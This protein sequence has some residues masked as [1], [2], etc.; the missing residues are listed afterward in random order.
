TKLRDV[1][2]MLQRLADDATKCRQY[3][4]RYF[5][6]EFGPGLLN[7]VTGR[8]A[9]IQE[10]VR[11]FFTQVAD[12]AND[13]KQRVESA[14][15]YCEPA[16]AASAENLDKLRGRGPAPG[17]EA[18]SRKLRPETA[19]ATASPPTRPRGGLGGPPD[20]YEPYQPQWTDLA[21]PGT[22]ARDAAWGASRV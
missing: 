6:F 20:S 4:D 7:R 22:L 21:S 15:Q 13:R 1:P 11:N 9:E 14:A 3:A 5:V 16:A 10:H 17:A 18:R 8:H 12:A 2:E 19:Q